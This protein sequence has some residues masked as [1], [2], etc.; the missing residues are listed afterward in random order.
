VTNAG[1]HG[2]FL[3]V[4]DLQI[5]KIGRLADLRYQLMPVFADLLKADERNANLN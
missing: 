4:L 2:K 5:E 3:A 1:S